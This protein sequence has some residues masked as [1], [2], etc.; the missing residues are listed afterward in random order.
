VKERAKVLIHLKRGH[1]L[2]HSLVDS[3]CRLG[4]GS[5]DLGRTRVFFE[6]DGV[7]DPDASPEERLEA[8]K[9]AAQKAEE[10]NMTGNPVVS[11]GRSDMTDGVYV[12]PEGL[13]HYVEHHN[14]RL[15]HQF[16]QHV[17]SQPRLR[18]Q[19]EVAVMMDVANEGFK[20]TQIHPYMGLADRK[21]WDDSWWRVRG[22][23]ATPVRTLDDIRQ[24][25]QGM[26]HE[27]YDTWTV[28]YH[29]YTDGPEDGRTHKSLCRRA[30]TKTFETKTP[31]RHLCDDC[32]VLKAKAILE[33][34]KLIGDPLNILHDPELWAA[35]GG[36]EEDRIATRDEIWGEPPGHPEMWGPKPV[37]PKAL[38]IELPFNKGWYFHDSEYPDEGSVGP[39]RSREDA[40]QAAKL[41]DY[42]V[43]DP[44]AV[45]FW[46]QVKPAAVLQRFVVEHLR[47]E[48]LTTLHEFAGKENT[49]DVQAR[50]Q[51][52]MA[53]RLQA[54]VKKLESQGVITPP[55]SDIGM[56]FT[57]RYDEKEGVLTGRM[58]LKHPER[59]PQ[60]VSD[61]ADA[62]II[63][64]RYLISMKFKE[65]N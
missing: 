61:L 3:W 38:E 46:E 51:E 64:P 57:S 10:A 58:W 42:D 47:N 28:E 12:W 14:V 6:G 39:Y 62:G 37:T 24:E 55:E 60:L 18:G 36:T 53:E 19:N 49:F 33:R 32:K 63:E 27:V 13:A 17:L 1:V 54:A 40:V 25:L 9:R 50:I 7:R 43:D 22:V 59:Y 45:T 31:G 29:L 48:I 5:S 21:L 44:D 52:L 8:R 65:D 23:L 2:L 56:D 34:Q 4:C 35:A 15:P 16:V 20:K 41:A 26:W 11:L 30:K